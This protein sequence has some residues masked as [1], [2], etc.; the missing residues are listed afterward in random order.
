[1]T[2]VVEARPVLVGHFEPGSPQWHAARAHGL[3]GSEI[4]A[5]LG[6][7]R[8]ESPFSLWHRKAGR[9]PLQIE[10]DEMEAGKLLEPVILQKFAS[11]HPQYRLIAPAGTYRP[12][13]R[14]WQVAN[15]DGLLMA[16]GVG[17]DVIPTAL[18]EAKFALYPDDW[19]QPGTDE[20]PPYYVAQCR[21]YLDV[22]GLDVC[23]IEVFIGSCAE[24]RTYEIRR[25][26]AHQQLLRDAGYAFIQSLPGGAAEKRPDID[27]HSATYQAIKQLADGVID[28]AVEITPDLEA[29]YV[30]ALRAAKAA[31]DDKRRVTSHLLD[32]IGNYRHADCLTRRVATRAVK[33]DGTTHS[34]RP[35][36]GLTKDT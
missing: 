33:P 13:D 3:G 20:V 30:A 6:L 16:V 15:P 28:E 1:V 22:F 26:D 8:F 17:L 36:K 24:F 23:Y 10:N 12:A 32:L 34:L 9:I 29:E 18:I 19:G 5:V 35:A 25:D 31:D 11:K 27:A 21:W 4:A 14:P 7:S 2:A